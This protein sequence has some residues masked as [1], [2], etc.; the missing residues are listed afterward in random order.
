MSCVVRSSHQIFGAPIARMSLE[1]FKQAQASRHAGFDTALRELQSGAK[2]SHWIWYIFPQL[3]GLGSS[4]ASRTYALSDLHDAIDYLRDPL[5]GG[6]L[7]QLTG[8]VAEK[9]AEGI[10]LSELM[11]SSI[12]ALKLVSSL[13]LFELAL[14]DL[15]AD[16]AAL[17]HAAEFGRHSAEVLGIAEREGFARCR[18]TLGRARHGDASHH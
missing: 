6:R 7:A 5:L 12:D 4:S 11:G 18:Y 16:V 3:A 8:L 17:P 10:P 13:T 1:R 2:T 14:R 9:L 15:G